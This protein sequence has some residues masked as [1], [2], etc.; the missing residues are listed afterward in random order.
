VEKDNHRVQ[1]LDK[2][3]KFVTKWG[4]YG[5]DDGQF[6]SPRGIAADKSGNI[7]VLDNGNYRI[8]KFTDEGNFIG[9]WGKIGSGHGEF[10]AGMIGITLFSDTS[11]YILEYE[12]ERVQKFTPKK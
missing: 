5:S 2:D 8:E 6:I 10:Q 11:V 4:S 7:Y 9:K 12:N 1:K 3:G